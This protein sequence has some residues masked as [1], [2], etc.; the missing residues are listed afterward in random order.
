MA[1]ARR[2]LLLLVVAV[3]AAVA[4]L[5]LHEDEAGGPGLVPEAGADN[6]PLAY[7][8]GREKAFAAAAARGHAHVIYAKS[9]GGARASAERT[10]RFRPLIEAAA[11]TAGIEPG[12]LEG[13]VLLESAGRPDAVADP[14]LE[15]AVGLTQILA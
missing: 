13:M 4:V 3:L 14:Q 10:A 15:G 2:V 1:L 12:T 11:K 5:A 6:D 7:S 9:P 8:A